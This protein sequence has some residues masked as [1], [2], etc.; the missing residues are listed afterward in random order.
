MTNTEI[1]DKWLAS[2]GMKRASGSS[3]E[4]IL[5]FF[6]LDAAYNMWLKDVSPIECR[7]EAKKMKKEWVR[8]YTVFNRQFFRAFTLDEQCEIT[9]KMDS[10]DTYIGNH[11]M[12]AKVQVMNAMRDLD[13][14]Q[15][16]RCASLLIINILCQSAQIVWQHVYKGGRD[17]DRTN[18]DILALERLSSRFMNAYHS[19]ISDRNVNPNEC[20]PLVDAVDVLCQK[21]IKWLYVDKK[22]SEAETPGV[23]IKCKN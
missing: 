7:H 9:D 2:I 22:Q 17:N 10:F 23:T 8:R 19:G 18:Q 20:K 11:V 13:T 4:P 15:A 1:V 3:L 5:P 12:V 14:D 21:M 16:V 6:M